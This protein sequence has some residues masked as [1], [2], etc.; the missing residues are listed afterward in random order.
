M[1]ERFDVTDEFIKVLT[2]IDHGDDRLIVSFLEFLH[3]SFLVDS[4]ELG[5]LNVV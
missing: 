1:G 3:V 5:I 2:I 4:L